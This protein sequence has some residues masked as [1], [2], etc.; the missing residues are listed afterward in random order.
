MTPMLQN[1]EE[2][3]DR[4]ELQLPPPSKSTENLFRLQQ[5]GLGVS[6]GADP[7]SYE[8]VEQQPQESYGS[9]SEFASIGRR[10]PSQSSLNY[11]L[12]LS[13]KDQQLY[14]ERSTNPNKFVLPSS[15]AGLNRSNQKRQRWAES[16]SNILER[17]QRQQ[18]DYG[19]H[20]PEFGN[21]QSRR[22]ELQN[23]R[24]K[25]KIP[26]TT[27]VRG[28]RGLSRAGGPEFRSEW[29]LSSP[30]LSSSTAG[31]TRGHDEPIYS[32]PGEPLAPLPE[33]RTLDSKSHYYSTTTDTDS[34]GS[35]RLFQPRRNV[36]LKSGTFANNKNTSAAKIERRKSSGALLEN[37]SIPHRNG[38]SSSRAIQRSQTLVEQDHFDGRPLKA[39]KSSNDL[40][41]RSNRPSS[42]AGAFNDAS[43]SSSFATR[44]SDTSDFSAGPPSKPRRLKKQSSSSNAAKRLSYEEGSF[45]NIRDLT[46]SSRNLVH[47]TEI[48]NQI[49]EKNEGMPVSTVT[50][51][52]ETASAE[53]DPLDLNGFK[54]T[55]DFGDYQILT[56]SP[57]NYE[58]KG[59]SGRG[60][61]KRDKRRESG[62]MR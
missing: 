41:L 1:V 36:L 20:Y 30:T 62:G 29:M 55:R 50:F 45:T 10:Q 7:G 26:P 33:M 42:V 12:P 15:S 27:A 5:R 31:E 9:R 43:A 11:L 44:S 56:N 59:S 38:P 35:K 6:N 17:I 13:V 16:E 19:Y 46:R 22:Y 24:E 25:S 32:E 3:D 28:S 48:L 14:Q 40:A 60:R 51:S 37:V 34:S 8:T 18:N 57:S 54:Q 58:S 47:S 61:A 23:S 4:A 21:S 53:D 52:S 2:R 49:I 39:S